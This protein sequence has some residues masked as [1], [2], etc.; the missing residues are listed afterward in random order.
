MRP[1]TPGKP[2]LA[3]SWLALTLFTLGLNACGHTEA[4]PPAIPMDV[5]MQTIRDYGHGRRPS[6]PPAPTIAAKP[7][8]T[9][10]MYCRN[11]EVW[12]GEQYFQCAKDWA[13]T[14]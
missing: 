12:V 3:Q 13:N 10:D 5:V 9:D 2:R 11:D 6:P 4:A 8:E 14:L 1:Y 7:D